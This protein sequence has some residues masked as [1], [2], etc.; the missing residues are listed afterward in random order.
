MPGRVARCVGK[1]VQP[2]QAPGW[3]G[4]FEHVFAPNLRAVGAF[5]AEIK[6][7]DLTHVHNCNAW[8]LRSR[9]RENC[10]QLRVAI[11]PKQPPDRRGLIDLKPGEMLATCVRLLANQLDAAK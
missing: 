10:I 7:S 3:R 1:R 11:D 5:H 6:A 4:V 9:S 8:G 2:Q